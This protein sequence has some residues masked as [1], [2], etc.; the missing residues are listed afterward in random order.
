[1]A[2][3]FKI[4]DDG[5]APVSGRAR[6]R[7]TRR[8]ADIVC[9]PETRV[10]PPERWMTAD[11]LDELLRRAD[12]ALRAKV[13]LRLADQAEAP[14]VLLRRLALDAFEVAEPIIRRSQ[15]LTDF[16]MMEIARKGERRHQMALARREHVSETV[17]AAL[18]SS[19]DAD[20]ITALLRNQ[21]ARLATQTI[22]YLVREWREDEPVARL[23][24]KRAETRPNQAFALFWSVSHPLRRL[25]LERFSVSRAI[26]QDAAGDVFPLAAQEATPDADVAE[27][28]A[29]I[30]RRQRNRG[31]AERSVYG[32]L[33]RLIE[34]YGLAPGDP[35]LLPEIASLSGIRADLAE[36]IMT[37]LGGEA[38]AVLVKATGLPRSHLELLCGP[39]LD[40]AAGGRA[41]NA[42][43]IF[44]ILSVDKAQ[45]VLRYWNWVF[46][47]GRP[48]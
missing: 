45:T 24:V 42:R 21:G 31:A 46:A 47:R 23:L 32:S 39:E 29:Y 12:P 2:E 38:L 28:L 13:A 14:A 26:L 40:T 43:L 17:A 25:V 37:D 48:D 16:D 4:T 6:S 8:L 33:E 3:D 11:V 22:D 20:V 27:A 34:V 41:H 30:D 10:S 19:G 36:R 15:G 9:L 35:E 18:A 7:L 44:D 1:M 5:V